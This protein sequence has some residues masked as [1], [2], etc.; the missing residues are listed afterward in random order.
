M[1]QN[2]K[3]QTVLLLAAS[4]LVLAGCDSTGADGS[5]PVGSDDTDSKTVTISDVG[6]RYS[7]IDPGFWTTSESPTGSAFVSFYLKL[8]ETDLT[9]DDIA[10][11]TL[12]SQGITWTRTAEEID[13]DEEEGMI[14]LSHNFSGDPNHVIPLRP[15]EITVELTNGNLD[16]VTREFAPP[17]TDTVDSSLTHLYTEDYSNAASPPAGYESMIPRATGL[18]GS[19]GGT[20]DIRINFEVTDARVYNGWVQFYDASGEYIAISRSFVSWSD[21]ADTPGMFTTG[22]TNSES[23]TLD[24]QSEDV[25]IS[26]STA[27]FEDIAEA[28]LVLTDGAQYASSGA[29]DFRSITAP[30]A[31]Q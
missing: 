8:E 3:V 30:F 1:Q 25:E 28:V 12:T 9:D 27:T 15:W 23:N 17:G 26:S 19:G 29:Y 22:F 16:T 21:G 6:W 11:T 10:R 5:T 20:S 2:L 18:T 13:F 4:V 7:N 14:P 24:I 31:V